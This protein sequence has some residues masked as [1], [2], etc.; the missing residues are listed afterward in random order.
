MAVVST[1]KR[2][3]TAQQFFVWL[4][5]ASVGFY[6]LCF[7]GKPVELVV[8]LPPPV[9]PVGP[10]KLVSVKSWALNIQLSVWHT[11][12]A[13]GSELTMVEGSIVCVEVCVLSMVVDSL[14]SLPA[15]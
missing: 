3:V 1:S 7:K 12:A 10:P 13:W 9:I 8:Q 15:N 6:C 11:Y 4:S 14:F 5:D 2:L